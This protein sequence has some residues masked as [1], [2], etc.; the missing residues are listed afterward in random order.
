MRQLPP[1]VTDFI[2]KKYARAAVKVETVPYWSTVRFLATIGGVI[3]AG[4]SRQ[5]FAYGVGGDM[6]AA[7]RSGILANLS[8]TNLLK[9]GETRQNADLFVAGIAAYITQDSEPALLGK[10]VR[11]THIEMTTDGTNTQPLG[12]LEM[13]PGGGG[14]YGAGNSFLKSP[15]QDG[16]GGKDNGAGAAISYANNGNPMAG[17][18]FVLDTPVLWTGQTGVD[19]NFRLIATNARVITVPPGTV[20]VGVAAG[21]GTAGAGAFTP[22]AV[23]GDDGTFVDVR[24]RLAV[25]SISRRSVN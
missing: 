5:A 13:F 1:V 6:A 15:G 24:F 21:A 4:T 8:D 3:A 23:T 14:L 10:I 22:P 25:W 19:S 7:G 2:A 18:F 12:T 20:R 16:I 11:E 17:N 9:A